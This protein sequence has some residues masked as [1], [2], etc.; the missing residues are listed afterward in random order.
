MAEETTQSAAA[1]DPAQSRR[2]VR[3]PA[4]DERRALPDAPVTSGALCGTSG[5]RRVLRRTWW[6]IV[7]ISLAI[8][9][10]NSLTVLEDHPNVDPW[11]PWIWEGTSAFVIAATLWVPWLAWRYGRPEAGMLRPRF[12]FVHLAGLLAFSFLHVA[13]FTVLRVA[14][15][16]M[17]GHDYAFDPLTRDFV[18]ELRKDAVS[19]AIFIAVLWAVDRFAAPAPAAAAPTL[20][21]IREGSRVIRVTLDRILAVT[22]AGNYV[23]FRLDDGRTPLMRAPL[24]AIE[25]ELGARGFV[26]THRSW[27]VNRARVTGLRPE[28]SG[29]WCVELG[30]LEAP[31]SRRFKAALEQLR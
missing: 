21:D 22:S 17:L 29:D 20:Y 12:W 26:R 6:L 8:V 9:V 24:A 23:E 11:E 28:G 1:A 16:A 18:Y 15:Y 2:G 31:L 10:V 14:I 30:E 4:G 19:Y 3:N 13:G 27:L 5:E 7:A 25:A